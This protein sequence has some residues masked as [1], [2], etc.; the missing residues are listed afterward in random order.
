[1]G[2][3]EH[4]VGVLDIAMDGTVLAI[5]FHAPGADI[6][7]FEYAAETDADRARVEDAL[8]AL[9]QPLD[10][11]ALPAAAGCSVTQASAGLDVA[12]AHEGEDAHGDEDHDHAEEEHSDD[13]HAE[14][15]SHTEFHAE[16]RLDCTDPSAL[17]ELTFPYFDAFENAREV[18]VQIVTQAGAQAFEVM[19]DAPELDLAGMF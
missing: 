15:A 10:L 6:V 17:T 3:H 11:F 18:E 19:R 13:D 8:A 5:E 7:S 12:G 1:M 14:E 2:A 4:G 16:Y 9:G